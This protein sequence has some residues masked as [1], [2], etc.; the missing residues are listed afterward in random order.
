MS[1]HGYQVPST[2]TG[3]K[4]TI[5]FWKTGSWKM[6]ELSSWWRNLVLHE[7]EAVSLIRGQMQPHRWMSSNI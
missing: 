1:S 5:V 4:G 2:A 3:R 6:R 7:R